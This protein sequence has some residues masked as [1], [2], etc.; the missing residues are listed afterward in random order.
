MN[1]SGSLPL[2]W[3]LIGPPRTGAKFHCDPWHTSA[4][5][6]L[7]SGYKRWSLY[8][9]GIDPPGPKKK[10]I[11]LTKTSFSVSSFVLTP[12]VVT[13][14]GG[15]TMCITTTR[16]FME[17]YPHLNKDLKPIEIV[18]V[19]FFLLPCRLLWVCLI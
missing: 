7:T 17:Y 6:A 19:R 15:V 10:G 3:M 14:P 9:P 13:A 11:L 5:N 12:Y 8:P 4:W 16:W 1:H 18:Q 2:R